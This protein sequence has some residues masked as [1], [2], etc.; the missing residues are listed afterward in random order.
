MKCKFFLYYGLVLLVFACP[1]VDGAQ[2]EDDESV[3]CDPCFEKDPTHPDCVPSDEG[4]EVKDEPCKECDGQGGIRNKEDETAVEVDGKQGV[5]CNGEWVELPEEGDMDKI[6]DWIESHG[7]GLKDTEKAELNNPL[8]FGFVVCINGVETLCARMENL[9]AAFPGISQS[10]DTIQCTIEHEQ[11]HVDDG[12]LC[13]S[14]PVGLGG[15]PSTCDRLASEI[16]ALERQLNC[17]RN[18]VHD[19]VTP[20]AA[21]DRYCATRDAMYNEYFRQYVEADCDAL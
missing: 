20:S 6:C 10:P 4:T 2:E 11:Q 8:S 7:D 13:P 3:S 15:F 19:I 18:D 9:E 16:N 5:C 12:L 21:F 17:L 1:L 14:C